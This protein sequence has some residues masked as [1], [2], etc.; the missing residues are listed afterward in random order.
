M[1]LHRCINGDVLPQV[2]YVPEEPGKLTI[3]LKAINGLQDQEIT[4]CIQVQNMLKAAV[5]HAVPRDT[6]VNK[7]VTLM[8]AVTPRPTPVGCLWDFGDG[9]TPAHTNGTTTVGHVYSH[10]GHYLVKV[11]FC[12]L[13]TVPCRYSILVLYWSLKYDRDIPRVV[14]VKGV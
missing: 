3:Y 7:T 4:K 12:Q 14:Y 10:P 5:L 9:S 13:I 11:C 2:H 8:V 6:F 1:L